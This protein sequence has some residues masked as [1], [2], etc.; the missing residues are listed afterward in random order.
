MV[1]RGYDTRAGEDGGG[2]KSPETEVLEIRGSW[3]VLASFRLR[4]GKGACDQKGLHDSE[5]KERAR[6]PSAPEVHDC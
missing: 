3:R 5:C 2:S 6:R 1:Q 4:I